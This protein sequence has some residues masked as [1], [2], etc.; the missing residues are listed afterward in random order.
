MI[1]Q[2]EMRERQRECRQQALNATTRSPLYATY[3]LAEAA[4]TIAEQFQGY[5]QALQALDAESAPPI[6]TQE[7]EPAGRSRPQR[8]KRRT[9]EEAAP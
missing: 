6:S 3:L 9:Q 2:A 5:W 4:W 8:S 7:A 1:S